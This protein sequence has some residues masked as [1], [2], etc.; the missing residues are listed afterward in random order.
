MIFV[1]QNVKKIGIRGQTILALIPSIVTQLIAF[2]RIKKFNQ[3]ALIELGV[4]GIGI[5]LQMLFPWP[6]GFIVA[7][8]IEMTLPLHYVRKWTVEY[9]K[10]LGTNTDS[11]KL[12]SDNDVMKHR[13]NE[14][15]LDILKER[16]A[17]GKITKEEYDNLKKE[18]E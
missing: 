16:L 7:L 11:M 14:K 4:I 17:T 6:F 9:N 18:F 15:A 10:K 2:Y 5:G 12:D 1:V 13:Q 3:G 8:A